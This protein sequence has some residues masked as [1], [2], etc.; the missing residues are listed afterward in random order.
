MHS[1]EHELQ[2][3]AELIRC[4]KPT[5]AQ[6]RMNRVIQSLDNDQLQE[7]LPLVRSFIARFHRKRKEYLTEVLRLRLR[8]NG[9]IQ[10]R[11]GSD[12]VPD[13]PINFSQV[14]AE[15]L[16]RELRNDLAFL[17][18]LHI[19]QW[20][21]F[22]RDAVHEIFFKF[23]ALARRTNNPSAVLSILSKEFEKHAEEIYDKGFV[24]LT[25]NKSVPKSE[26]ITKSLSGLQRFLELP[27]EIYSARVPLA[28]GVDEPKAIRAVCS[29]IICGILQ[30]YS[31][32]A[33][34]EMTG[35]EVLPRFSR[36]W[37]HYL[38]FITHADL[39][40]LEN[41]L[42]PGEFRDGLNTVVLP[43]VAAIDQLI[44]S[45]S[46]GDICLPGLGQFVWEAR[47]LEI[48]L[49]LPPS[50]ETK[51]YLEIHCYMNAAFVRRTELEETARR[52]VTLIAAPLR[53]DLQDWVNAHDLLRTSVVNTTVVNNSSTESA[54]KRATEILRFDISRHIG[55]G[56]KFSPL[57][58]NFAR[59]FPLENPFLVKYFHVHRASVRNLIGIFEQRTGVRLWCSVRRSGKTTASVDLASPTGGSL[60]VFQTCDH[61]DQYPDAN[62][63]YDSFIQALEESMQSGRNLSTTFFRD[64]V[65]KCAQGRSHDDVKTVFVL[66]EYETLF[67]RMRTAMQRDRALRYTIVQP[68]LNQMVAFSRQNLLVFI[69]QQPD[70]HFIIMDQ[71]QLSPYVEQ[72]LFPLFQ[73]SSEEMGYEFKA[74]LKKVLSNHTDFDESF[75]RAVYLESGGHPYLTVNLL[76]NFFDWLI[77]S[78]RPVSKLRFTALDFNEFAKAR[79]TPAVISTSREYMFFR[80]VIGEALSEEGESHTPWLYAVYSIMRRLAQEEAVDMKCSRTRFADIVGELKIPEKF[81]YSPDHIL[82]TAVPSN[83]LALK[84]D[85]VS[86]RIP[87]MARIS[88]VANPINRG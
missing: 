1:L 34:D 36:A 37:A 53:P 44:N 68:L 21:T 56:D 15:A 71:N 54:M 78:E 24:Y 45:Q 41:S 58:Y 12:G 13:P 31:Q 72:D 80:R 32:V 65:E 69:G 33:F 49:S 63:F 66:D 83:F 35:R 61:T 8:S 22:Y 7:S 57:K 16:G 17:S 88:L 30:G 26:A 4:V 87:L 3:I 64:A 5:E 81:G 48:T 86:P 18:D 82:S 46:V 73:H 6:E 29:A 2:E 28:S 42:E 77:E 43:V 76:V 11:D 19:F 79:L 60:V 62:L 27:I 14:D 74:L 10:V 39:Q 47:R 52:G 40:A 38:G 25:E 55:R 67:G 51:H 85:Q 23:A 70:A 20:G 59:D 75:A 9:P 84:G 50:V